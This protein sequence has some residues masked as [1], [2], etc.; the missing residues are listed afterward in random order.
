MVK[1]MGKYLIYIQYN[2]TNYKGWQKQKDENE[3][4]KTIQ[5]VLQEKLK[6]ILKEDIILFVAGRTDAK[7]HANEQCAHFMTSQA[8]VDYKFLHS[9][10][11]LLKTETIG[12]T[13]IEKII[14]DD[15]NALN[16]FHARY[17]CKEK[18]YKY[19]ILHSRLPSV[20]LRDFAWQV[21]QFDLEIAKKC[22]ELLVG[23]HDFSSFRD[24]Q[25]QAKSPIRTIKKFH[26]EQEGN[27][28]K[29]YIHAQSFLHHQIRIM[30]GTIHQIIAQE[31]DASI[32]TEIL[33]KKDRKFAGPTAPAR[34]LFL[35]KIEY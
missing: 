30:I 3:D 33:A 22:T 24:A 9:I 11:A 25:C 12:V 10:N 35:E 34:G 21:P 2:G 14:E 1:T 19:Q 18:M 29:I 26:F 8:I 32:I 4:S 23:T 17:S 7:V 15:H 28:H 16:A 31:L 13:K 27:L 5:S 20:F 6:I